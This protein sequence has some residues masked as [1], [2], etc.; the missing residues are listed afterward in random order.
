MNDQRSLRAQL[1]DLAIM[2]DQRGLYDAADWVR[3]ALV[4]AAALCDHDGVPAEQC[5]RCRALAQESNAGPAPVASLRWAARVVVN[6]WQAGYISTHGGPAANGA[7]RALKAALEAS[8]E[9]GS[10]GDVVTLARLA[11]YEQLEKAVR[12]QWDSGHPIIGD[13]SEAMGLVN[14]ANALANATKEVEK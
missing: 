3:A 1:I 4:Q 13:V 9:R 6:Q 5:A 10:G 8:P 2:A 12:K 14:S 7:M 11:A